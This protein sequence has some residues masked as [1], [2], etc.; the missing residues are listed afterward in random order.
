MGM[1]IG[2]VGASGGLG[3]STLT[4]GLAR[5]ALAVVDGCDEA[6]AV[7]LDVRGGLDTTCALEHAS[8]SR[9]SDLAADGW[10]DGRPGGPRR[11]TDLPREDGVAV[12]ASDGGLAREQDMITE[13]LD[14]LAP[15][16]GLVAVDC[17]P[18]PEAPVLSRLDLLVI[19]VGCSARGL[20]D[21][22]ALVRGCALARTH[23]V[24]VSRGPRSERSGPAA[25]RQLGLPFLVHLGD[26]PRV[27]RA[28]AEGLAP[29]VL[30]SAVD[31]VADE[32]LAMAQTRWLSGVVRRLS[33]DPVPPEDE[34]WT[35]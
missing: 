11:L 12:L 5:R 8:G 29:A 25:A 17:G 35:A 15:L 2:V 26:D 7:D 28:E 22:A 27:R 19:L 1:T 34:L 32:V 18:R 10:S 24:V 3:A 9:W 14:E 33:V 13:T 31:A 21:G 23:P 6:L 20:R 16:V 4:A 30:R